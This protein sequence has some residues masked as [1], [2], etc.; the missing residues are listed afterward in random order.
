M[1]CMCQ[2]RESTTGDFTYSFRVSSPGDCACSWPMFENEELRDPGRAAEA[3][4]G[5]SFNPGAYI[6]TKRRTLEKSV[7]LGRCD[8]I[9]CF[10]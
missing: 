8:R 3:S 9:D 1:S 2:T 6:S 4:R 10:C 7:F 5:C